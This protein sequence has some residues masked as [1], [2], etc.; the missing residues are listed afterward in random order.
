VHTLAEA[1]I[2]VG[3][4]RLPV[5]GHVVALRPPGG[6]EDLLLLE[7]ARTP[8]GDATLAVALARR[9]A[10]TVEDE[11]LDWMALPVP[12][13][14]T[15][16]LR[17]RQLLIGDRIRA[18]VSCIAAGCGRR[19][20]IAFGI[21]DFLAHHAPQPDELRE[22]GCEV[23]A[24]GEPGWFRL[25]SP[26]TLTQP[27]SFRLPTVADQLAVLGQPNALDTL[28]RRCMRPAPLPAQVR[29]QVEAAMEAL[30]PSLSSDLQGV[31]PECGAEVSVE[32]DARWFC[33][34][35]L[36]DRAVFIYQEV[37]LLARRYHWSERDILALPHTRRAAYAELARRV[38][39][40]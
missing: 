3:R 29:Q 19:I 9:L 5:S 34:R 38:E 10:R 37:D 22:H 25:V 16:M 27:V 33:L 36:R 12:D 15:L 21:E 1:D 40:A 6:A 30:A 17:L 32:F 4:W 26:E 28:A 14:D 8:A 23:E 11:P 2:E 13:L 35:E 31:C 24:A 39:G 20:D 7:A 18:D